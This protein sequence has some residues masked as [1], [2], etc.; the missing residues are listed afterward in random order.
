VLFSVYSPVDGPATM[1]SLVLS[2][3]CL[4]ETEL[5]HVH[6][7]V[8]LMIFE[9]MLHFSPLYQIRTFFFFYT[10]TKKYIF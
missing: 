2:S 7:C 1:F 8:T 10:K 9:P 4:F 5:V 6:V 3:A